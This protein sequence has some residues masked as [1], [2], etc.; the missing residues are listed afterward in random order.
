MSVWLD[1]YDILAGDINKQ[2]MRQ[3][4]LKN[5]VVLVLSKYSIESDWVEMELEEAR[6]KEKGEKRDVLCPVAVD[7]SWKSTEGPL[8]R[9]LKRDK[10]I[11]D[12]SAWETEEEFKVQFD[13]LIKGMQLN[14]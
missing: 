9:K 14:Y 5:I 11:L 12:F 6:K 2:V 3:I 13:K 1:R 8:W 7:D 4:R 10:V